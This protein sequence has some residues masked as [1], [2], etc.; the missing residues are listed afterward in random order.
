MT[1]TGRKGTIVVAALAVSV[2]VNLLLAGMMFGQRWHGGPDR[3]GM[4]GGPLRDVPAEARPLVKDIFDANRAAFDA[5]RQAVDEARQRVAGILQADTIDQAQLEAALG[6]MQ[7][8]MAGLFAL[9]QTVMVD[10]ANKLPPEL[11][12]DWAKK[13]AEQRRWKKP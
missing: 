5:Q 2:C 9:G 4:F 11:R 12:K 10:V 6:D 13:W 8:Q 7:T 3:G 1:L